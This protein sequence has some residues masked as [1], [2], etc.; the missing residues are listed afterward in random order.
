M[1]TQQL[2]SS[3]QPQ[4]RTQPTEHEIFTDLNG[5]RYVGTTLSGRVVKGYV[6]DDE[7]AARQILAK[8]RISI[9]EGALTARSRSAGRS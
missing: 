1:S 6:V 8:G 3:P 4:A 2:L 9:Q 7:N 5:F